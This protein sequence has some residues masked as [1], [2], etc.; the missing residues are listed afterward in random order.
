MLL[1]TELYG[2][3]ALAIL[4][5]FSWSR[6]VEFVMATLAGAGHERLR[7]HRP[8]APPVPESEAIVV[9]LDD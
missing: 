3:Y 7:G 8:Y 4:T 1:A 2:I 9:S 6:P 5:W